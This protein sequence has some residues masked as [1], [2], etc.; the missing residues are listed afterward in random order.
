MES[1]LVMPMIAEVFKAIGE[2]RSKVD[3]LLPIAVQTQADVRA[4]DERLRV[5]EEKVATLR[6]NLSGGTRNVD[7]GLLRAIGKWVGLNV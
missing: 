6:A 3:M 1:Q 4:L 7:G 2:F 5:V